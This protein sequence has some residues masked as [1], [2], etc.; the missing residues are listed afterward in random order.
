MEQSEENANNLKE[1][2]R[3][4]AYILHPEVEK[5]LSALSNVL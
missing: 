3:K 2:L 4:K 1:I 5:T